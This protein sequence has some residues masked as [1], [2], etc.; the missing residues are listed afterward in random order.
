MNK[1]LSKA[2]MRRSKLKNT[3]NKHPTEANQKL[4]KTQRNFCVNLLKKE[5]RK[6]YNN[7][8]LK[9][10]DDNKTFWKKIKPLFSDKQTVLQ[11]NIVTVEHGVV[12]SKKKEVAE[13]LNNFFIQAVKNLNIERFVITNNDCAFPDNIE[14]IIAHYES[15]PSVQKTKQN[16][17]VTNKFQF[18]DT[19]SEDIKNNILQLDPTK[20][21][22]GNDIPAKFLKTSSEVVSC[23]LADIYN[24]CKNDI[25]YSLSLKIA[26]VIPKHKKDE[27]TLLKNYCPIRLIPIVSKLSERNMHNQ[28]VTYIDKFLS[29]YLFGYRKG[30]ITEQCLITML[31]AWRKALDEKKYAGAVLTDLS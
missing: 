3:F 20:A 16:V 5:K 30:Y 25:K 11:K 12:I 17:R 19:T 7:L 21:S 23:Y 18:I 31:E 1:T 22:I 26:G 14:E 4:Y 24:N 28:A 27:K 2:F 9:I 6:Y 13:K 29:P 8:D 15:H 10:F